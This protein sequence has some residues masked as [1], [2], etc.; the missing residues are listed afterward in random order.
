MS[1]RDVREESGILRRIAESAF[2]GRREREHALGHRSSYEVAHKVALVGGFA[3]LAI[4]VLAAHRD[5]A[6]GYEVSIYRDTVMTYWLGV[7]GALGVSLFTLLYNYRGRL[8][9]LSMLLGGA[10]VTSFLALPVIRNYYFHGY[11]DPMAH[12]GQIRA[13][14]GG[15]MTFFA[16]IYPGSYS[17]SILIG[18]FGG[19]PA[20]R[21]MLYVLPVFG[22]MF[23]V[24]VPLA[25]GRIVPDRRAMVLALF[26]SF[27][28]LPINNVALYYR[29]H[30]FS[31][32]TLYFP[33]VAYVFL[34]HVVHA[35]EDDRL[36]G[37]L[38]ASTVVFP[39]V[40]AG[41]L[42]VHPQATA[43]VLIL[44]GAVVGVQFVCRR[45]WPEHPIA[46]H[47]AIYGQFLF[48]AVIFV[49]WTAT[50][51]GAGRTVD[52]LVSGILGWFAGT[53][54]TAA[55]V[56]QRTSSAETL[57]VSI[58][59]L[60]VKLFLVSAVYSLL[61]AG[62]FLAEAAGR[63]LPGRESMRTETILYFGY[64]GLALVPFVLVHS[65]GNADDYLFRHVGFAVAVATILGSVGLY[66]CLGGL[67]SRVGRL[68]GLSKAVFGVLASGA[69]VLAL[70][71]VYSSPFIYLPGQHVSSYQ[72]NGYQTAFEMQPDDRSVWYGGIR[73]AST[74]YEQ[75]LF[76]APGVDW[77]GSPA[78]S[79][80]GPVADGNLTDLEEHYRTHWEPIVRR[81]HVVAVSEKS[82]EAEIVAYR[83][84][85]YS[86]ENISSIDDQ[87]RVYRVY[88]NGNFDLYYV[89][90]P[91][92]P[93]TDDARE[94]EEDNS[95][96]PRGR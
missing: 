58:Y 50:H 48:L 57:D 73:Q 76:A 14:W 49:V 53:S 86:A 70:L 27:L 23:L 35:F 59:E 79:D 34:S 40:T 47:R 62:V 84:V 64:G 54:E 67:A 94:A 11:A 51:D 63:R 92:E 31:L 20:N 91:G 15:W 22:L 41:L 75:A 19:L 82:Y 90:T 65:F 55:V 68:K 71:S 42:F 81:D 72:M 5:P 9:A 8:A 83:G 52:T 87:E 3:L 80:S 88:S 29:F 12:L 13:M 36:P 69:L 93:L 7:G 85:R 37:L 78:V 16:P 74:R 89:D 10:S 45:L 66:F 56:Q 28:L 25:V 1:E 44:L 77:Q 39:L 6:N 30:P 21:A 96:E 38:D 18:S 61:A 26:G 43:D 32:A 4:G 24:F 95:L 2:A 33:L 60:F 46:N 17:I